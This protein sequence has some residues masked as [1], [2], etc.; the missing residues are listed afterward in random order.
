ML[1]RR[2][3]L[4][5]GVLLLSILVLLASFL[6]QASSTCWAEVNTVAGSGRAIDV[7]TNKEPYSGKGSNQESDAFEPQEE[8]ILHGLVTYNSDPVPGKIVSFDARGPVNPYENI[9]VSLS[10]ATSESGVADVSFII[11]WPNPRPRAAIFGVWSVVASVDIAGVVV[12]DTLSFNTGWIVELVYIRTTDVNGELKSSF[13]RGESMGFRVGVKNIAMTDRTATLVVNAFDQ[14]NASVGVVRMEDENIPPGERE[15]FLKDVLIPKTAFVGQGLAVANALKRVS[16]V[17]VPWCE[18]VETA[19]WI[20]LVRD[21]AVLNVIPSARVAFSNETV[22]VNVVV[23]N[24]GQFT[25]SFNVTAYYDSNWIG[26]SIVV[27]LASNSEQTLS[28]SW[29]LE[30]VQKGEHRIKAEAGPVPGETFLADNV[31][32]DGLVE[33]IGAPTPYPPFFDM[34]S[35]LAMLFI[36]IVLVAAVFVIAVIILMS[37]RRRKEEEEKTEPR[38]VV[39]PVL[40]RYSAKRCRVCGKEFAAVYTFCPHCMSF[41][42]KDFE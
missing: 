25:E 21:V 15:Y 4:I 31:Y 3:N 23:K 17:F 36:L 12:T 19:F 40:P 34:R 5:S 27:N 26:T 39:E 30:A 14:L 37:C 35:L 10:A 41:H 16:D 20:G 33:V 24:K 6:F 18:E 32:I 22:S 2:G 8:I 38:S 42:G 13:S 9:S 29:P 7:Y 11:P 1:R 28:I